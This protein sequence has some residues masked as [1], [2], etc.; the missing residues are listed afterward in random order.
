MTDSEAVEIWCVECAEAVQPRLTNGEE[1]SPYWES[2]AGLPFWIHD[3]CG[4]YVGC[5]HKTKNRTRPLGCIPTPELRRVRMHIH[6]VI[7]PLWKTT[8]ERKSLYAQLSEV[9]GREFHVAALRSVAEAIK[10][11]EAARELPRRQP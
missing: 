7:D 5:H 3:A 2:F 6:S 9:L 1:V 4:N 8:A 11:L 10:I